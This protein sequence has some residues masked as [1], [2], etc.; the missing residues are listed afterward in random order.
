MPAKSKAQQRLMGMVHAAQKGEK[1]ASPKVAKLAKSMTKKSATDFASTKHKGLPNK[2]KKPKYENNIGEIHAVLHPHEGCSVAGMVKE[3]DPLKGL[4]PHSIMAEE[5]HSLHPSR[6]HAIKEAHKLHQVHLKKL[7][8]IEK[9]K[10]H[11]AKKITQTID[12][13]EKKRKGHVDLAKED[14]KNARAHKE[15]I[16]HLAHQIDDLMDKLEKVERSKKHKKEDKK[17]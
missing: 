7:E 11:V 13:L 8:E 15:H 16:A 6:E 10:D 2:K 5:V 3:I 9:K 1:P 14:P 4:A 17:K 12:A